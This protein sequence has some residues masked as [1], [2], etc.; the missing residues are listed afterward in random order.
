MGATGCRRPV[1]HVARRWVVDPAR[2]RVHQDLQAQQQLD[3][4]GRPGGIRHSVDHLCTVFDRR[5]GRDAELG[6]PP[7]HIRSHGCGHSRGSV[8]VPHREVGCRAGVR[9]DGSARRDAPT[10]GPRR[11]KRETE[12]MFV[13]HRLASTPAPHVRLAGEASAASLPGESGATSCLSS[14]IHH[15]LSRRIP[16]KPRTLLDTHLFPWRS[17]R[18]RPFAAPPPTLSMRTFDSCESTTCDSRLHSARPR[19]GPDSIS[20]A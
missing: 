7:Q 3:T 8:P 12:S 18:L 19:N 13:V 14:S 9:C 5:V 6:R 10:T 16:G 20:G 17:S 11:S 15:P 1:S 4:S 2:W